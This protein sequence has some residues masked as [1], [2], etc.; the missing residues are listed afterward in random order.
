MCAA[1]GSQTFFDSSIRL[2]S[3]VA[4]EVTAVDGDDEGGNGGLDRGPIRLGCQSRSRRK[5]R[6]GIELRDPLYAWIFCV[7]VKVRSADAEKAR[8][9]AF[10]EAQFLRQAFIAIPR[11]SFT[12]PCSG[13]LFRQIGLPRRTFLR[14]RR[15]RPLLPPR[16]ERKCSLKMRPGLLRGDDGREEGRTLGRQEGS[17][18]VT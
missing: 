16:G 6:H 13:M 18:S 1:G 17:W 2:T 15:R 3:L 14:G 11:R 12:P 10:R 8:A 4:T 9:A 5:R 7:S